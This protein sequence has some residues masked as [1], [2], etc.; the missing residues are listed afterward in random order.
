MLK[1]TV[2]DDDFVTFITSQEKLVCKIYKRFADFNSMSKETQR[3]VKAVETRPGIKCIKNVFVAVY[4][5][6]QF[7]LLYK[8]LHTSFQSF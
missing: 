3:H 6:E 4:L 7:Y 8:H 2:K 5:S 1:A